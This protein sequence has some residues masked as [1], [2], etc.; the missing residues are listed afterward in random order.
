MKRNCERGDSWLGGIPVFHLE[1]QNE[2]GKTIE[3]V[4]SS[5]NSHVPITIG[6]M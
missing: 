6:R 3:K 4:N 5:T 1:S 2:G